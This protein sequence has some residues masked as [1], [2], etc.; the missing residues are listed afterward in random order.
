MLI[1]GIE[2]LLLMSVIFT[3][4]VVGEDIYFVCSFSLCVPL[5]CLHYLAVI[6]H[7]WIC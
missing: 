5:S 7:R 3:L 1:S 2:P 6:T 4:Q